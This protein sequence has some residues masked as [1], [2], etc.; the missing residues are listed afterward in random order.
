V[1]FDNGKS[2]PAFRFVRNN[3]LDETVA[4]RLADEADALADCAA[5]SKKLGATL[6]PE[7]DR[8]RIVL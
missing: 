6:A 7:G 4:C 3:E 2:A 8:V 5:R 1:T